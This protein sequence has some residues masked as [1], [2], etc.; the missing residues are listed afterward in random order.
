ME[1]QFYL[2]WP[3]VFGAIGSRLT[4]RKIGLG[5][6]LIFA[7]SSIFIL[8]EMGDYASPLLYRSLPTRVMSLLGGAAL[9]ISER[10]LRL[11]SRNL[12]AMLALVCLSLIPALRLG[13]SQIWVDY[14]RCIVVAAFSV[15]VL[16]AA[17]SSDGIKED[18]A[19][20]WSLFSGVLV[21]PMLMYVGRISYGLYLYHLIIFYW[22]GISHVQVHS[23]QAR[24]LSTALILSIF[25]SVISF[26]LVERRIASLVRRSPANQVARVQVGGI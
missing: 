2:I 13:G 1:E 12:A 16:A 8:L 6:V 19:P 11:P 23:A 3:F 15:S 7:V 4:E 14:I 26:E 21:S 5:A 20:G 10:E 17:I 9:A 25:V 24:E 18:R 22:F